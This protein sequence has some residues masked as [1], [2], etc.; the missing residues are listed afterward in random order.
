MPLD[1]TVRLDIGRQQFVIEIQRGGAS[2]PF[3]FSPIKAQLRNAWSCSCRPCNARVA[4]IRNDKAPPTWQR[5]QTK[6]K[7][8]VAIQ[9][10]CSECM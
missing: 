2:M 9:L 3:S 6:A 5:L 7:P 1:N 4:A 8:D 10:K